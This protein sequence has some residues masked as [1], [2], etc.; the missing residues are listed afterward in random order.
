MN[1]SEQEQEEFK[2]EASELIECMEKNFLE[3]EMGAHLSSRYDEVFRSLHN[4]KGT[5]SMMNFTSLKDLVHEM[6]TAFVSYKGKE[7]VDEEVLSKLILEVDRCKKLLIGDDSISNRL[8]RLALLLEDK[9]S[10]QTI[11]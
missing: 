3:L 5:A 8:N 1:L 2:Q 4:L 10:F 6:E 9:E 7:K 11:Q